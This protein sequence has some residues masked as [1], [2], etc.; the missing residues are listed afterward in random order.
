MGS[1]VTHV[2]YHLDTPTGAT[3]TTG[4]PTTLT[5]GQEYHVVAVAAS[6]YYFDN[7]ANDEWDFVGGDIS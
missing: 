5:N 4:A 7:N 3:L 2:V 6:G 1:T